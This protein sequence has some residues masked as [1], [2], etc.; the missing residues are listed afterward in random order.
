MIPT[1]HAKQILRTC[2]AL[3]AVIL[4]A[5][6]S[7]EH[8]QVVTIGTGAI[9]GNYR[10]A[11]HAV[12]R[13]VRENQQAFEFR[14]RDN[15]SSGS[16]AN[17]KAIGAGE[18][19]FGIT[20]ADHQYQA[21]NGLAAWQESGPQKDLRAV[22]SLYPES[23]TLV[24]GADAGI[25]SVN[26]L[27]GRN[28]DIGPPGSGTRQNAIDALGAA[29]LDWETD[30]TAREENLDERLAMLMHGELDAFFYTIGHPSRDVK[31][32]TLSVRGA[33]LIAMANIDTLLAT[34]PYYSRSFISVA[35][36]PRAANTVNVETIG[37]KA[38]LVTSANVPDEVVYAVTKAVFENLE[39]LREK[40]G[41]LASLNADNM[42]DGLTAPIHPGALKYFQEV[43][44]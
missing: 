34:N 17:I 29:G 18:I 41:V 3:V 10:Q 28:I 33:R 43:G 2:Q 20:Q 36:Y 37:V 1:S 38:T 12:A 4:V 9:G 8:V 21:I 19:E 7:Q 26:D 44:L 42:L 32:A 25:N 5:A 30:L 6:C 15:P 31:Y 22:L 39:P 13:V 14:V 16:V 27:K 24:A 40:G 35:H 11:G 23:V